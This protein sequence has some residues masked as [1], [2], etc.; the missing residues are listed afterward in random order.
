MKRGSVH[1][2]FSRRDHP[3][4]CSILSPAL[5]SKVYAPGFFRDPATGETNVTGVV[6]L[7]FSWDQARRWRSLRSQQ[8]PPLICCCCSG[9]TRQQPLVTSGCRTEL[10][11][12]KVRRCAA[13]S[14]L[15]QM[16]DSHACAQ[17][18]NHSLPSFFQGVH[19]VVEGRE[20]SF[21]LRVDSGS[22]TNI[23]FGAPQLRR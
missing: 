17:V 5:S 19:I 16:N 14:A 20:S 7:T 1:C 22:V 9:E 2:S 21:T 18:I 15:P 13:P 4:F 23:G 3:A 10:F 6:H 11:R 12:R 8:T